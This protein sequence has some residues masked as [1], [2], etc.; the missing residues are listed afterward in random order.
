MALTPIQKH[1]QIA[2]SSPLGEDVLLFRRMT[3]TEQLGRPFEFQLELFSENGQIKLNDMLGKNIT[4]RMELHENHT[5]YFN[6]YVARFSYTFTK[7]YYHHY[8]M[9]LRPWL[10][11]LTRTADCR[12]FQAMSVPDIVKKVFRDQGFTD[13]EDKLSGSY[14]TREYCVQYRETDFN[15]VSRLMEEE[16]IYYYFTH[17]NSKHKLVLADGPSSHSTTAGYESIPFFPP[18]PRA[19]RTRDHIDGWSMIG[20]VQ[21]GTYALDAFDFKLPKKELL[22]Q[23]KKKPGYSYDSFE[24]FDYP[25]EYVDTGVGEHLVKVRNEEL[26]SQYQVFRGEGNAGGLAAGALF[27]LTDHWREDQNQQYLIIAATH[28]LSSDEYRSGSG[29]NEPLYRGE[30]NTIPADVQFRA[31]RITPKSIIQGPQ[32]AI[33]VGK[34]GE[35]IDTDEFGRVKVQFHWD[36]YGKANQDSSCWIRVAQV[37]AGKQWGALFLPRIGQEVIVEFLEGDPDQPIITGRVYNGVN[38]TPYSLPDEKTKSTLKSNSSKGGEG[39][40]EIR[41]EDKKGSEQIFIHGEKDEDIR[42]KNDAREWIGSERHMIV[43]KKQFEQVEGEKHLIIKAGDGGSGDQ[44]EKVEG[45]KHQTVQGDHNQKVQGTLSLNVDMDQQEKVGMNHALDAGMNI[46][47]KAGM[48]VVIEGGV[49]VS[50]KVGGSFVDINPTGVFISGPMVMINSG[51]AAG[52]G[53]GSSPEAPQAPT[54]PKEADDAKPGQ[55]E[56]VSAAPATKTGQQLSSSAIPGF[57]SPSPQ[58]RA[59]RSAAKSGAPFCEKCEEAKKKKKQQQQQQQ[60][61]SPAG[62]NTA[63]GGQI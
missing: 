42:I 10:W 26:Q 39:F 30:W 37:W 19:R 50:L 54:E 18:D 63:G 35:E 3:A 29:G 1:R 57:D 41:L 45:D 15:F 11:L 40:N 46:H 20:Q 31:P 9:T 16:G 58:A 55:V 23:A 52:S 2:V 36:R 51:G 59:L 4:L 8:Q 60:N 22:V 48:T 13:F 34:D 49:Q 6:G 25:G 7:G 61:Q 56:D 62:Q 24:I 44:F 21:P 27:S 53:S 28:E 17:E 33:V 47:L 12:I 32:T 14:G 5:R 38:K 43:K